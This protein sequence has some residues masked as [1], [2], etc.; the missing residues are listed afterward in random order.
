MHVVNG[1]KSKWGFFLNSTLS[2]S[3]DNSRAF[4]SKSSSTWHDGINEKK[5]F[6]IF[7]IIRSVK[8]QNSMNVENISK[9]KSTRRRHRQERVLIFSSSRERLEFQLTFSGYWWEH[10]AARGWGNSRHT[11]DSTTAADRGRDPKNAKMQISIQS[12]ALLVDDEARCSRWW[13]II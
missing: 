5:N 2:L 1:N 9:W 6:S 13:E 4:S 10:P 7:L 8:V 11:T 3:L 12:R